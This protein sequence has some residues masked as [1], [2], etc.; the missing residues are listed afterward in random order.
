MGGDSS[1]K[2]RKWK[3][4]PPPL[5]NAYKPRRGGNPTM[6]TYV[7]AQKTLLLN[8]N[9]FFL[10]LRGSFR[11]SPSPSILCRSPF[12]GNANP[13]SSSLFSSLRSPSQTRFLLILL[14]EPRI[15][16]S[17]LFAVPFVPNLPC[18]KRKTE[19]ERNFLFPL[20]RRGSL[21]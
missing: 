9:T 3:K 5:A 17:Y 2:R 12:T 19:R 16:L 4:P 6:H 21:Y 10:S 20:L 13:D 15:S 1:T 14:K 7:V 8:K 18:L 11:I